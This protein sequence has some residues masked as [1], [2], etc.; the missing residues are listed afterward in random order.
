MRKGHVR[1]WHLADSLR[2]ADFVCY[3]RERGR[4]ILKP[5]LSAFD[6]MQTSDALFGLKS[7]ESYPSS[8]WSDTICVRNLDRE[9]SGDG[10][11]PAKRPQLLTYE[12]REH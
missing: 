5:S 11:K 2:H 12:D 1:Q 3:L 8:G 6:P 9:G 7:H 4:E 10:S